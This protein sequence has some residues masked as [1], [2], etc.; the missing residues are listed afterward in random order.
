MTF[1]SLAMATVMRC[2]C[3]VRL[4]CRNVSSRLSV[5]GYA[6]VLAPDREFCESEVRGKY[7]KPPPHLLVVRAGNSLDPGPVWLRQ[8]AK[9]RAQWWRRQPD[10]G[11]D[12]AAAAATTG[13]L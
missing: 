6:H 9:R 12:R 5:G 3:V 13:I 2:V 8:E 1:K 11:G 10:R 7:K 4:T